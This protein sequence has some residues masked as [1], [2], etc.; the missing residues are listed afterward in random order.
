MMGTLQTPMPKREP[1]TSVGNLTSPPAEELDVL[2]AALGE[3]AA[4]PAWEPDVPPTPLETDKKKE[5][6]LTCEF[7]SWMEII[8]PP[9]PVTSV[10]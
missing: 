6:A 10:G 1:N 4:S 3:P 9:C 5:V 8:H 2:A 7:P